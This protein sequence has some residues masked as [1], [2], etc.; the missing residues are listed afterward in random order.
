MAKSNS[1]KQGASVRDQH[2]KDLGFGNKI[3]YDILRL[4]NKDGTFNVRRTGG[5]LGA[6][7]PYQLL[8]SISWFQFF[9]IV[10]AF[11]V[12]FNTIFS[13]GYV[14]IGVETIHVTD[15]EVGF[16]EAFAQAFYFSVQTFSTVGY[17]AMSP[18]GHPANMLASF[19]ALVGLLAFALATGV[20]FGRFSKPSAKINFSKN[21]IIAPYQDINAFEFRIVNRRKNQLIGLKVQVV[22]TSYC[23]INNSWKQDFFPLELERSE[24][25][26]FPMSW[27]I[28]HPITPESP[29]YGLDAEAI[30]KLRTEFLII[31][32]GYDDTFAQ[33]VHVLNSYRYD[34]VLWGAKF[35]KNFYDDEDGTVVVEVDK[36]G[37]CEKAILNEY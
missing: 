1:A 34:E 22:M 5:G 36:V 6:I 17:G 24:V 31:M 10:V 33:T 15:P 25:T 9:L 20:M 13:L 18:T 30:A 26:L 28:V 27:T 35:V 37:Q 23:R 2:F 7:H 3:G 4:I 8:I 11:F 21:A 16:W 12:A 14:I 19:E 32:S 29:L